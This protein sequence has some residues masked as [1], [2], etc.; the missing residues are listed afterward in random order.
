MAET[1]SKVQIAMPGAR[2]SADEDAFLRGLQAG[3]E[4]AETA[5]RRIAAWT[6]EHP[7]QMVLASLALGFV[8]GKLMIGRPQPLS[9]SRRE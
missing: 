2:P 3:R 7:G 9:G 6:E 4:A 8:L 5:L 1:Q